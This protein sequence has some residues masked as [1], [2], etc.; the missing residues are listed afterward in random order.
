MNNVE[1]ISL[2]LRRPTTDPL[3]RL[4]PSVRPSALM[5]SEDVDK[6]SGLTFGAIERDWLVSNETARAVAAI[7]RAAAPYNYAEG[8]AILMGLRP[9][10]THLVGALVITLGLNGHIQSLNLGKAI[11]LSYGLGNALRYLPRMCTDAELVELKTWAGGHLTTFPTP[12]GSGYST[13]KNAALA[14][15]EI[16]KLIGTIEDVQR[17]R[18]RGILLQGDSPVIDRDR[19]ELIDRLSKLSVSADVRA[20]LDQ[21]DQDADAGDYKGAMEKCRTFLERTYETCCRRHTSPIGSPPLPEEKAGG[22]IAPWLTWATKADLLKQKERDV[23][24]ALSSFLAMEGSH[25]TSSEH[26]Q[27]A[28]GKA[29]VIE[30]CLLV[31]DR[32]K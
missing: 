24:Q 15:S 10:T 27:Y 30:W 16:Q 32:V 12:A 21:A 6:S 1:R 3:F 18:D 11:D 5:L 8:E 14:R 9:Q 22:S 29:C 17:F 31:A 25:A 7:Y 4:D 20:L 13:D 26:R 2:H 23:V 19:R 28:V